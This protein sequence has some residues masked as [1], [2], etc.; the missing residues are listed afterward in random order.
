MI[1]QDHVVDQ[2]N[3]FAAT[4]CPTDILGMRDRERLDEIKKAYFH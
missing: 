3:G 4:T 1:V 2:M